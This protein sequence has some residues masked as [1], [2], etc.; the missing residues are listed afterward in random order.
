MLGVG[1]AL[2]VRQV[3]RGM[4]GA[5]RTDH[6]CNVQAADGIEQ[7]KPTDGQRLF[8]TQSKIKS[9]AQSNAECLDEQMQPVL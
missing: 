6:L 8:V 3:I 5:G 2:H 7:V 1:R 4:G 9:S